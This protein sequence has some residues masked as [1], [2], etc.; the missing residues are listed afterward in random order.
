MGIGMGYGKMRHV[1]Y[2][3]YSTEQYQCM[4]RLI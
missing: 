4:F 1:A 3:N 2:A